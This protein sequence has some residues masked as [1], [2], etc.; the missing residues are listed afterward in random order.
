MH[1]FRKSLKRDRHVIYIQ[2]HL[3]VEM[4]I[5]KIAIQIK[6]NDPIRWKHLVVRPGMMHTLMSF[7]KCIGSWYQD[8]D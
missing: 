4:Q 3:S 5:Y 1:V 6:W 2:I 8:T 7:V